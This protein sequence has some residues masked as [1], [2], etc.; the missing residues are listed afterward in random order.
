MIEQSVRRV[1]GVAKVS[2]DFATHTAYI[3]FDPKQVT[4]GELQRAI[5]RAGY[6]AGR[7]PRDDARID[8][9]VRRIDLLRVVIA[10][11]AA[12]QC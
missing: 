3:A 11:L 7:V 4:R 5:E 10:W 12:T 6:D 9:Q 2:V 8:A 1:P